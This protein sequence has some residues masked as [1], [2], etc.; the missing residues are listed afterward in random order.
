MIHYETAASDLP[1]STTSVT[2]R[3]FEGLTPR[4]DDVVLIDGVD[5]RQFTA[6]DVIDHVKR[7]AG[8]LRAAGHVPQKPVALMAPNSPEY[9][10]IFHAIA[11]AG[12]TITTLNPTYTAHEIRHQLRDSGAGLLIT[13]PATLA[14]AKEALKELPEVQICVIGSADD[15]DSGDCQ[16]LAELYGTAQ[17]QQYPVDLDRHSVALPYSSG[18]TGLPKGVCLSHRSLSMNIDQT[19]KGAEFQAGETAAAFLPFFHIYGMTVLMNMHLAC[20]G[21]LVTMPRFD[22]EVFLRICQDHRARRMWIVPPV[23]LALAKHPLVDDYDLS[24]L[25]QVF[26]GAAPM[27]NAL[28]DAV[29]SRFDCAMLQGYGMTELAPVSHITPLSTPRSGASGLAVPNT[30]CRIVSPE[31]GADLPP[32]EEGELWI[33]GPQVMIGYLNNEQATKDTL[34]SD[35]WLKT[36]DM[37][38]IDADGYMFV[39]DRLKELIKYKGFQVAPAELEATL[40]AHPKIQD[41]AVIGQHDEE[42]GEIPVAFVVCQDPAPSQ[43]EIQAYVGSQLSH[44]KQLH[45]VTF[46]ETIPKSPS[47]K[48]LRRLLRDSHGNETAPRSQA[49]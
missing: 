1:L 19:A 9:C 36:G 43:E 26:S 21:V 24:A 15:D 16:S 46:V 11:W 2:E 13:V 28:S 31:T 23:A 14:V 49:R 37:A 3:V 45:R 27:G 40:V 29:A 22:L 39:V 6:G 47:G 32:G 18:T 48:I 38:I 5:G 44:Y 7:L 4:L 12:G 17:E 34:T 25:E 30:R 41:A 42:A 8:G 33:K 20:G 10:I 35:G